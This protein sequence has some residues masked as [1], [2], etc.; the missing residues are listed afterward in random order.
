[1]IQADAK[2]TVEKPVVVFFAVMG[3]IDRRHSGT[4]SFAT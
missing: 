3:G 1:V 2:E 4:I